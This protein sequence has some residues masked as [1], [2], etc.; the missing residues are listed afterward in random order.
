MRTFTKRGK[1]KLCIC[2]DLHLST[3]RSVKDL[4]TARKW[5]GHQSVHAELPLV[6]K[7]I[8]IADLF[9]LKTAYATMAKRLWDLMSF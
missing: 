2:D 3:S 4:W 8:L 5:S 6:E 7:R 1:G 9:I